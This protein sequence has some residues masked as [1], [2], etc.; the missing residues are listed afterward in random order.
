M[1]LRAHHFSHILTISQESKENSSLRP[2]L[3]I[4][5]CFSNFVLEFTNAS[6]TTDKKAE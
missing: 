5:Q 1:P 2:L 6:Q 3:L 4:V